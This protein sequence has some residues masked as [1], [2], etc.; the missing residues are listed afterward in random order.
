[1]NEKYREIANMDRPEIP[2][3]PRMSMDNRAKIF[4]PFAALKGYEEAIAEKDEQAL[5]TAE[6]S[7]NDA[8]DEC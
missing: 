3:H 8:Y 2:G 1:M 6:L 5:T 4:S 7:E